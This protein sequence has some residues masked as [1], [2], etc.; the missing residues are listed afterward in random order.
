MM[1]TRT[2][3]AT[4][5]TSPEPHRPDRIHVADHLQVHAGLVDRDDLDGPGSR[6]HPAADRRR[7]EGRAGRRGRRH[8][9][10][11]VAED[12]LAVGPDV[13][14][15]PQPLVA[16]HAGGQRAG[17]DVAADVRAEGR[18]A[19][20]ARPRVQVEPELARE[21]GRVGL[22]RQDERRH[23]QRLGVD[24]EGD[25]G[26]RGVARDGHLV[27]LARVDPGLGAHLRG[28]LGQRLVGQLLQLLEGVR[29]EH[30]G[31]DP[32]DDVGAEG[33]LVVEH[34]RAPP[35][36]CRWRGPA[37]SRRRWWCRGRTRCRTDG[38]SCHPARRRP[39]CRRRRPP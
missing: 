5:S 25:L 29:V 23:A 16:V 12:D 28:E 26:H 19:E 34:R 8:E 17:D 24:A 14:E 22:G 4:A 36:A 6:A 35:S 9:P 32:A 27:D 13:D 10:L 2:S 38:R 21:Q 11:A 7:L 20:G 15:Q 30:R 39:A 1:P 37:A 18:E 3:S 33:L 31:A